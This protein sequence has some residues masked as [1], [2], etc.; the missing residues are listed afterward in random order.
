MKKA[1]P[2]G[3]R[4]VFEDDS[5]IVVDKPA[6]LLTMGT[7]TERTKTLYAAPVDSIAPLSGAG[8][9]CAIGAG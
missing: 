4:V 2:N 6:G 5:V 8:A 3:I 7:N 9:G 1:L